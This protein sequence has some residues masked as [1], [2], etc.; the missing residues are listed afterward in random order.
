MIS[1]IPATSNYSLICLDVFNSLLTGS[2]RLALQR[3]KKK[4]VAI[5]AIDSLPVFEDLLD[6]LYVPSFLPPANVA[7]GAVELAYGWDAYLLNVPN[8]RRRSIEPKSALIL[9]GGSDVTNLGSDLPLKLASNLAYGS[10]V[11]YVTGP[12]SPSPKFPSSSNVRFIEH[13]APTGLSELM[14]RAEVA[15]TVFGVSFFELAAVGVPTVVFSPYG[16]KDIREL[17]EIEKQGIAVV[18]NNVNDA[19]EKT[20]LLQNDSALRGKLS[21]SVK[22]R[23]QSFH[24]DYFVQEVEKLMNINRSSS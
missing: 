5:V 21:K 1:R 18:A 23:F 16:D 3:L 11:R 9:T 4:G 10:V 14:N 15:L 8:A 22:N 13:I 24:G 17:K 2:L 7:P 12:Y 6:L 20:S 19:V